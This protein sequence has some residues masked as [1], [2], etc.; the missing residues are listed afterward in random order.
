MDYPFGT[1]AWAGLFRVHSDYIG[2]K[3]LMLSATLK[4]DLYLP[5]HKVMR[6]PDDV[7]QPLTRNKEKVAR[8]IGDFFEL[9]MSGSYE[10]LKGLSCFL[11][12]KLGYKWRDD[13]SGDMGFAYNV[14]EAETNAKEHVYI[15]G[16]QYS[17]I[18]SYLAK[19]FPLPIVGSIG[20]RNR[21]AG[22]N[23]LKSEY[24][25]VGLTVYF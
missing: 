2:T 1:G 6:I 10:F 15:V 3:N 7:D 11:V 23:V 9:E 4:Y 14:A 16:L 8:D 5:D 17:T 24:I 13:I 18:S 19:E 20:Y 12:Y 22:E 25:D 21:F